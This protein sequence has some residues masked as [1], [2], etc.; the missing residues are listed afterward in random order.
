[1]KI[2]KVGTYRD[3][4]HNGRDSGLHIE[5]RRDSEWR[6]QSLSYDLLTQDEIR[7]LHHGQAIDAPGWLTPADLRRAILS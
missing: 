4:T 3:T 6:Y 5:A 1:M 7:A 2:H